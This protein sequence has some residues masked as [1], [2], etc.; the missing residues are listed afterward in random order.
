MT[1][2]QKE[3]YKKIQA[4]VPESFVTDE[5]RDDLAKLGWNV[6]QDNGE[7]DS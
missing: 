6:I 5:I 4:H 3:L 7:I 1:D 2:E